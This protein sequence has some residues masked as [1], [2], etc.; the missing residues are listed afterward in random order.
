[1]HWLLNRKQHL[2]AY[3]LAKSLHRH[4]T[5]S[6]GHSFSYIIRRL[7]IANVMF[8]FLGVLISLTIFE[9][10]EREISSR[11]HSFL[12]HIHIEPFTLSGEEGS[13]F[14]L[15][16][17]VSYPSSLLR[18]EGVAYAPVLLKKGD[19]SQAFLGK[20][21]QHPDKLKLHLVSGRTPM[22]DTYECLMGRE[23]ARTSGVDLGDTLLLHFLQDPPRYR[24]LKLVGLYETGLFEDI[25]K[26][27]LPMPIS[28]LHKLH[29][30]ASHE[31]MSIDLF[32][33]SENDTEA[34]AS[35]LSYAL[36][37]G[38]HAMTTQEKYL[39]SV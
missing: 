35:R 23:A 9:G 3:F 27:I 22:P 5:S 2:L 30:K 21:V 16:K 33:D 6:G 38:L 13:Y 39:H 14:S 34:L 25:D 36:P 32:L 24:K 4:R 17:E 18:S 31:F 19:H 29:N 12:G 1:M 8:G 15:P 7:A 11:L 28:I 10:F 26:M 37:E 20:G